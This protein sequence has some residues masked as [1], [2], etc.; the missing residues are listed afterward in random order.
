VQIKKDHRQ[1]HFTA[2]GMPA[3]QAIDSL[4]SSIYPFSLSRALSLGPFAPRG[5]LQWPEEQSRTG[6][7]QSGGIEDQ[8]NI[9][10]SYIQS[11]GRQ[12][13]HIE[14]PSATALGVLQEEE[15]RSSFSHF[16]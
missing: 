16:Q 8:H 6:C 15:R 14:S 11:K 12:S 10:A 9:D 3:Q 2:I 4:S 13:S 7:D 1:A 5:I